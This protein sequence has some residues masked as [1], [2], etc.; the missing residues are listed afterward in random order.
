M[1]VL[2]VPLALL[3]WPVMSSAF[4]VPLGTFVLRAN[5]RSQRSIATCV[6]PPFPGIVLASSA[7]IG[8]MSLSGSEIAEESSILVLLAMAFI[9]VG[10]LFTDKQR[11]KPLAHLK[12]ESQTAGGRLVLVPVRPLRGTSGPCSHA[13][14]TAS[15]HRRSGHLSPHIVV[16]G[17]R[18]RHGPNASISLEGRGSGS[19]RSRLVGVPPRGHSP[20]LPQRPLL[21]GQLCGGLLQRRADLRLLL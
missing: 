14:Y 9:F 8:H 18:V 7:A 20:P 15:H 5:T 17:R 19:G 12:M 1:R 4:S 3:L 21:S 13:C 16:L 6:S 10:G 11:L 2:A